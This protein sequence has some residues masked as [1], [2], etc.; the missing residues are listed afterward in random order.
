MS[1]NDWRALHKLSYAG[2]AVTT[3]TFSPAELLQR[4][5]ALVPVLAERAQLTDELRRIPDETVNDLRT[6]GLLRIANP[7]RFGGYG[8]D[9]DTAL[10]VGVEL[11]RGCG[12]T[13]WCYTVWSSH[14][15]LLGMYPE[16]AQEEYFDSPDVLSSSAFAPL[17]R[18]EPTDGGYRLWG[19]WDFSSG[20]DAAQWAVLGA[21]EPQQGPGLFLVPRAD[22]EIV[23][24]WFVSGLKGTGSKDVVIQ[25]QTFVPAHRFL[26]YAAMGA[27]QT[28]GREL[29]DRPTYRV[30]AYPVLSF[31]LACPLLGIALGALDAFE[32]SLRTRFSPTGQSLATFQNMHVR[33]GEAAAEIAAARALMR[34][35]LAE[36]IERGRHGD[37]LSMLDRARIRRDHAYI[38]RL[39]VQATNRLFEVAGGHAL[40]DSSPLQRA[41]RDVHAG[42]HQ[43]ALTWPTYAEQYGRALLGLEPNDAFI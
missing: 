31:T 10:E 39:S 7:Q 29:H 9:Y 35:D 11:G 19:R 43:V 23:D 12:S 32:R 20:C 22:Y 14:N 27:G 1:N 16:Q 4:A 41:H 38:A 5:S 18:V 33:M 37:T 8:L 15:W 34:V 30:A 26:S 6:A 25:E 42:S 2:A 40:F 3:A 28:H 36:L 13:A 21:F 24:T 17:G